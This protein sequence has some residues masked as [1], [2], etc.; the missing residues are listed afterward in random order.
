MERDWPGRITNEKLLKDFN[1][2]LR[3][4]DP[5]DP[6]NFVVSDDVRE[7]V[8]FKLLP[9]K[10]WVMLLKRFGGLEI[11]RSKDP[12]T[13]NRRFLIKFPAVCE[14]SFIL[15]LHYI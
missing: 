4:D 8:D 11:K 9:R 10:V 1:E 6:T 2:Y 5:D 12:D 13:Y 3:E 15:E 14:I 7:G